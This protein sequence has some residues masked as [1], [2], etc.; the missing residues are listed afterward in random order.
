MN[1]SQCWLKSEVSGAAHARKV[2]APINSFPFLPLLLLVH[3]ARRPA[4]RV[5][6]LSCMPPTKGK[7][8]M[9]MSPNEGIV[10]LYNCSINMQKSTALKMKWRKCP[11]MPGEISVPQV[12]KI[13][14]LVYVGGGMRKSTPKNA[15]NIFK[16]TLD[17]DNWTMLPY[18]KTFLHSLAS[19]DD[20]LIAIGG[21]IGAKAENVVFTLDHGTWV[22]DLPPM[23]TPRYLHSSATFENRVIVVAG[24]STALKETGKIAP[25]DSVEIYFKPH[26]MQRQWCTTKRLPFP[27]Q[28][29]SLNI[30]NDKCYILGGSVEVKD[31]AMY[32]TVSSLLENAEPADTTYSTLKNP[33]VWSQLRSAHPL[34]CVALA[35]VDGNIV[36][37]GGCHVVLLRHGTQ[38]TSTYDFASDTWVECK[39]AE[40]PVPLYR[41]TVVSLGN[42][43]VMCVGGQPRSQKFS[44]NVFIGEY[45]CSC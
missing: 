6:F 30:I 45:T 38:Y 26:N 20:K 37:M 39:G 42:N 23:P 10:H 27:L 35:E 40:L 29:F 7:K 33:F 28:A 22:E 18:C 5:F 9:G 43:E 11:D 3:V 31:Q 4:V 21:M 17:E 1:F 19:L 41:S 32:A 15:H 36:T 34:I 12:V 2:V 44:A 13:G 16:Y 14:R 25:T 24:G 8:S